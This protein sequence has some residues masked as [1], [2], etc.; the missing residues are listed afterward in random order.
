MRN[1]FFCFM[2]SYTIRTLYQFL[3]YDGAGLADLI[4][5]YLTR[6]IIASISPVIWEIIPNVTIMYWHHENMKT[7][8]FLCRFNRC[9]PC[10]SFDNLDEGSRFTLASSVNDGPD[11]KGSDLSHDMTVCMLDD[12]APT[13]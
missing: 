2:V 5:S 9:C 6:E 13:S 4:C 12:L 10:F 8:N 3:Y 7:V 1:M 11:T